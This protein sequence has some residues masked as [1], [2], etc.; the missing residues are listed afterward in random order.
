MAGAQPPPVI[1]DGRD[2]ED[3]D[4]KPESPIMGR[5]AFCASSFRASLQLYGQAA[6][7][8]EDSLALV[9]IPWQDS[10]MDDLPVYQDMKNRHDSLSLP[11]GFPNKLNFNDLPLE[12]FNT[13]DDL[14]LYQDPQDHDDIFHH[15]VKTNH[16]ELGTI[17]PQETQSYVS[18][19]D[20][21]D[22][23]RETLNIQDEH[24]DD[25]TS[26][27]SHSVPHNRCTGLD[28]APIDAKPE[29]QEELNDD[30]FIA[31]GNAILWMRARSFNS[32]GAI[33]ESGAQAAS[34]SR[35]SPTPTPPPASSDRSGY[36]RPSGNGGH[37]SGALPQT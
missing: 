12:T 6:N 35:P 24:T 25:E 37:S 17:K 19:I 20:V 34:S 18:N 14:P 21:S 1:R 22:L 13:Q 27:S 3:L 11:L 33:E 4:N 8:T 9:G 36:R 29:S 15:Q 32:P 26:G 23:P 31:R 7:Y 10:S 5:G 16:M 30:P 28:G 2:I